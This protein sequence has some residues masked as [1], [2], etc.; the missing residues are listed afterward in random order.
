MYAEAAVWGKTET[1]LFVLISGGSAV[2]IQ[3]ERKNPGDNEFSASRDADPLCS[4]VSNAVSEPPTPASGA[5]AAGWC[6]VSDKHSAKQML[7]GEIV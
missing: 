5:P 6:P 1:I 2:V 4:G 3:K 7:S